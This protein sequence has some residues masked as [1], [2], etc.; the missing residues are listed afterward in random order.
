MK[1]V[2]SFDLFDTILGKKDTNQSIIFIKCMELN[3]L[4]NFVEIRINSEEK[5]K[6]MN[7][8]YNLNNIYSKFF[9]EI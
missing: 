7:P 2:N 4:E 5:A 1:T 8:Y 3:K 6:Q 9:Y